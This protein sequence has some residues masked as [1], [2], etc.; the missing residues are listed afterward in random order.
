MTSSFN[1]TLKNEKLHT[2]EVMSWILIIINTGL[3]ILLAFLYNQVRYFVVA[4]LIIMPAMVLIYAFKKNKPAPEQR[5][6]RLSQL[7]MAI[8]LFW[9]IITAFWITAVMT[10]LSGLYLGSVKKKQVLVTNEQISYPS[11][12]SNKIKWADLNNLILKD[13]LLTIDF[14][15]NKLIQ[16]PIDEASGTVDETAFNEF[17]R[18]QLDKNP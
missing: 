3:A 8:P 12:P 10:V 15:N 7:L 11:F 5:A 13:G 9:A 18:L 4:G 16:Q 1:I 6:E 2:Y 14:K 17:C